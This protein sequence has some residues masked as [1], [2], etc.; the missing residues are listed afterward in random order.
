MNDDV[1]L[2]G[3]GRSR[4]ACSKVV[5]IDIPHGATGTAPRR[6]DAVAAG[7]ADNGSERV[8]GI[9]CIGGRSFDE[10]IV[11]AAARAAG[12]AIA[13]L[14]LESVQVI[15]EGYIGQRAASRPRAAGPE[16][17][18]GNGVHN[19]ILHGRAR[20]M[21]SRGHDGKGRFAGRVRVST[22][23]IE[24]V[25]VGSGAGKN[26]MDCAGSINPGYRATGDDRTGNGAGSGEA[27]DGIGKQRGSI[28][29]GR[30][31]VANGAGDA[32]VIRYDIAMNSGADCDGD[33]R[34]QG[35]TSDIICLYLTV[36]GEVSEECDD[37]ATPDI[38]EVII[39]YR[40][41]DAEV[42][43]GAELD[44][45]DIGV[46]AHGLCDRNIGGVGA[47]VG[48]IDELKLHLAGTIFVHVREVGG[49][50]YDR[51]GGDAGFQGFDVRIGVGASHV[52]PG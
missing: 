30:G 29:S 34:P 32:I 35:E 14:E 31:S 27:Y 51:G 21:S 17:D 38:D 28:W 36:F 40:G 25:T 7:T 23:E 2:K 12:A 10:N 42:V 52:L 9:A 26:L 50:E 19:D 24:G 8:R 22:L 6:A 15:E 43:P 16:M 1:I 41:E 37:I 33:F 44:E 49:R 11:N 3:T 20:D 47:G 39:A 5:E 48:S 18:V 46:F 13:G 4:G 45:V